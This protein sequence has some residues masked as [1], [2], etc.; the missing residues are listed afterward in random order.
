MPK[1]K[2]QEWDQAEGK[3]EDD[4][5]GPALDFS[6]GDLLNP[7]DAPNLHQGDTVKFLFDNE[8]VGHVLAVERA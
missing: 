4:Q 5:G 6:V 7:E 2:I 3:I 1:G 8:Q